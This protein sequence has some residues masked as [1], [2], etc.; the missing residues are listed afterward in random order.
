MP[1]KLLQIADFH[2]IQNSH[3]G[4]YSKIDILLEMEDFNISINKSLL[5]LPIT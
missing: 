5:S 1:L 3:F 4:E 2:I